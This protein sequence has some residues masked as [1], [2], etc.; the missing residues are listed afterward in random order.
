MQEPN[1]LDISRVISPVQQCLAVFG[2]TI[3]IEALAVLAN[4]RHMAAHVFPSPNFD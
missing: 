2:A 1:H 3:E 4:L